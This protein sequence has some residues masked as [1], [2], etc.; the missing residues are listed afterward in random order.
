M[1]DARQ[2][3]C[4]H[5][6][7]AAALGH[8]FLYT[9][10]HGASLSVCSCAKCGSSALSHA[11]FFMVMGTRWP[12]SGAPWVHDYAEWNVPNVTDSNA[13]GSLHIIVHLSLI[14]ISEPTRP[15]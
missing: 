3:A 5:P 2:I 6:A 14:H 9:S 12:H 11:L 4:V 1:H 15:Y 7:Q 13:P 10:S 8:M